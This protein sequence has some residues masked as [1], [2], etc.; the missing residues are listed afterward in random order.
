MLTT[1]ALAFRQ[2]LQ[3]LLTVGLD[4]HAACVDGAAFGKAVAR[5]RWLKPKPPSS[6]RTSP[7]WGRLTPG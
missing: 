6:S 1:I 3:V 7:F 5:W 4:D 2:A